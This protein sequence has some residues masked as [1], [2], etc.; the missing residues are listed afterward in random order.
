MIRHLILIDDRD[1]KGE[2]MEVFSG[3]EHR[4]HGWGMDF[5]GCSTDVVGTHAVEK[6]GF[7]SCLV[8]IGAPAFY[9]G[10]RYTPSLEAKK[11]ALKQGL[12]ALGVSEGRVILV[13]GKESVADLEAQLAQAVADAL[14]LS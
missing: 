14:S 9:S 10:L 11:K 8:V 12:V 13:E 4:A 2:R 3:L 1:S 5:K 6:A 7:A